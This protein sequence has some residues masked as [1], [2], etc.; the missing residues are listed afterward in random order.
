LSGENIRRIV[1]AVLAPEE[2]VGGCDVA[3]AV[4]FG[5][6]GAGSWVKCSW[7]ASGMVCFVRRPTAS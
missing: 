6:H 4:G 7:A 1:G 2:A 3:G 5:K